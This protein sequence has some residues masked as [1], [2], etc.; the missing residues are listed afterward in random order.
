[1]ASDG[2]SNRAEHGTCR[3]C[4]RVRKTDKFLKAVGEVRHGFVTGH[5]WECTDVDDCEKAI[6]KKLGGNRKIVN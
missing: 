3:M 2:I 1:M 4:L 5:I 6:E